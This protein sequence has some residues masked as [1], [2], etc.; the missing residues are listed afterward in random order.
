MINISVCLVFMGRGVGR[1][2]DRLNKSNEK[3]DVSELELFREMSV[4]I[5]YSE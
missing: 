5:S 4:V 3:C 1:V 2:E